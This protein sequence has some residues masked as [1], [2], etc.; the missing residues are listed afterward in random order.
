MRNLQFKQFKKTGLWLLVLSF[1]FVTHQIKANTDQDRIISGTVISEEGTPLPGVN[2][3]VRGTRIGQTSDFDGNYRINVPVNA[4]ILVFSYIGFQTQEVTIGTQTVINIT[5]KPDA[6]NL[7]EVVVIGY[8]ER[9]REELV[10]AVSTVQS[11]T[12]ENQQVPTFEQALIGQVS[13]VQFRDGGAPDGG[14]QVIVRGLSTF[15]NNNPLYVI[16][17]FPIGTNAGVQ[18][19][20]YLLNSI[21]PAD[22]ES[23]SVLKDAASKAIY[24]SRASNG[25]I[26]ITTKKGRRNRKPVIT[27]STNVGFQNVPEYEAPPVLNAAELAQ[28]T[29]E[30]FEDQEAAGSPLGGLQQNQRAFL[31]GTNDYGEDNDW[32]DLITRTGY[33]QNYNIAVSGGSERS[34]YSVSLAMQDREGII[35]NSSFT[36]YSLNFNFD[37]QISDK[38]RYGLNFAPTKSIATGGRTDSAAGNFR[39]FNA[40]ALSAWTDPTAPLRDEDGR[41]TAVADG[42]L[43]F[44]SRNQNPVTLMTERIDERRSD[45]L[46]L[47]TFLEYTIVPGLRAKTFGSVQLVDRRNNSFTPSRFP[48]SSL[49][50]SLDGTGRATANVFELNNLNMVWENTLNYRKAFG[51]ND[52][53]QIDLL[54]GFN[55]E[56]R[57]SSTT[58]ANSANLV[59][60][61]IKLPSA[62]NSVEPQDFT[63]GSATE[64]NGIISI[65]GRADYNYDQRYYFTST[66]RRDGSSKFGRD[67][68]YADF[69]SGGL[70][71]RI[72]NESFFESLKPTFSE[73]RIEGGYGLSGNNSNIGNYTAQ[74]AIAQGNDYNFDGV[75]AP[76]ANVSI[77][78]NRQARWEESKE[79]NFGVDLGFFNNRVFLTADYYDYTSIDFLFSQPLPRTSGFGSIVSNL[80]EIQNKGIELELTTRIIEKKDFRWTASI[81]YTRNRN[82]VID[83]PQED[84][85]FFPGGSDLSGGNITEVREGQPLGQFRGLKVTGLFTQEDLDNPDQPKYRNASQT[86]V[87]SLKWEDVP[88]IDTDGDGIP[89]Q[90]DGVLDFADV[91]T[92]GDSNP[93]FIFGFNTRINY[94]NFDLTITG[95]GAVGQQV[96]LAQNQ[97][98]WNQDD[99]QFNIDR[100]LLERYRPGDDPRTKVIPGTGSRFSRQAFRRTNSLHIQDADYLWVRNITL[101]YRLRGDKFNNAFDSVRIYFSAQNPFLFTEYDYGAPTVNRAADNAIV[102]NVDNG[103]Y[104]IATTVS[105]GFDITF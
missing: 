56:K 8:G 92:I 86:I 38:L 16:D 63:G 62:N 81:N 37:T 28:Y 91:T 105:L 70:A 6:T 73:F 88:T 24:G 75:N 102:R 66:W 7:D 31:L 33:V 2:V 14:P 94:K 52:E 25:V 10:G 11:T 32:F 71:W 103:A 19:D 4:E 60:E 98:L 90:A 35:I 89:D 3:I 30:Y 61:N 79:I 36:R 68:R 67:S 39:I 65:I 77:L 9:K 5:M 58:T 49:F 15:G 43:I 12:I 40:V 74:G 85:A 99:G 96:L 48:G 93:N 21:N 59:D 42:N 34:R 54:A 46:R 53:H 80:G 87:G 78:P 26:I 104:P 45:I 47:G 44:R 82:E 69:I 101:G 23:V 83:V 50:A 97:Y 22:I 55:M 18:R 27:M 29:L 100:V 17:G 57:Q 13:G 41:L 51:Q 84:N 1:I 76:G 72:S 20:N 95:D 64:A